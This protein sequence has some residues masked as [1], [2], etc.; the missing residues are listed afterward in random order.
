MTTGKID[1]SK[2][3]LLIIDDQSFIRQI[4]ARFVRGLGAGQVHEAQDGSSGLEA[5]RLY[6]PHVI[7]CDIDM[8]PMN[9][10]A[11][12]KALR[13]GK[14]HRNPKV[15]VIFLTS[16]NESDVV[17]QARNSGVTAFLVKPVSQKAIQDRLEWVVS[18]HYPD[19]IL[20]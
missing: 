16:H 17:Q 3:T 10:L 13:E 11:F 6:T 1:Y 8:I 9:G 12:L 19:F 14:D 2:L 18:K 7:F 15:P 4:I 20:K 5:C